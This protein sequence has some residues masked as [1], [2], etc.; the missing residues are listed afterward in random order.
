MDKTLIKNI[1]ILSLATIFTLD[2]IS[3]I[4]NKAARYSLVLINVFIAESLTGDYLF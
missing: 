4:E 2:F 3:T 1:I